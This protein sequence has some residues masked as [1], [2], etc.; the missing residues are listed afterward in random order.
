MCADDVI[1]F[2]HDRL[3]RDTR[4]TRKIRS[5]IDTGSKLRLGNRVFEAPLRGSRKRS[6]EAFSCPSRSLGTR[7]R[8]S[9]CLSPSSRVNSNLRPRLRLA[10]QGLEACITRRSLVTRTYLLLFP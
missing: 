3:P 6:F 10:R 2:R 1:Q 5:L 9:V 4:N 7:S 8:S